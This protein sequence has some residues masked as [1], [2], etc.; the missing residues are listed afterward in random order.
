MLACFVHKENKDISC[1]PTKLASG[2]T[3]K[4]ARKEKEQALAE[5]RAKAKEKRPVTDRERVGDVDLAIK[6]AKVKGMK[7]HAEKIAVDT[8]VSQVNLL[9]ENQAFYQE[10]H[11]EE[12]YK[13]MIVNLLNK[14]PGVPATEVPGSVCQ[15]DGQSSARRDRGTSRTGSS[16]RKGMEVTIPGEDDISLSDREDDE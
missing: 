15:D 3:R 8:I 10:V 13:K 11:G 6:K 2:R 5:E 1:K 9:R 14:L 4:D 16:S 12:Q 7:S